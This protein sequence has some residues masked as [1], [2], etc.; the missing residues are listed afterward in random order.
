MRWLSK[1]DIFT[2]DDEANLERSAAVNEFHKG[3]PR[4]VAETS[5]YEDW[6]RNQI[7]K[8]AAF[9]L[10]QMGLAKGRGDKSSE[11]SHYGLYTLHCKALGMDQFGSVGPEIHAQRGIVE[12]LEKFKN[13]QAD[14]FVLKKGI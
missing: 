1:Y 6:K 2:P 10:D 8:A 4:D 11:Q 7:V 14:V 13:H 3:M 5:A 12:P 9:H